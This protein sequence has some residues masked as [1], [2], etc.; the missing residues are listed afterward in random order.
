MKNENPG[1]QAGRTERRHGTSFT[2]AMF[3]MHSIARSHDIFQLTKEIPLIDIARQYGLELRKSGNRWVTRCP[4]HPDHNPSFYVFPDNRWCCFGCGVRGDAVDLVSRLMKLKPIEAAQLIARD[5]N[6]P[7][8]RPATPEARRRVEE[9]ARERELERAFAARVD[10]TYRRLALL[11]RCIFR[12]LRTFED[13]RQLSGLVHIQPVL[14][15]VLD[16]LVS[17]DLA[18]RVEALRFARNWGWGA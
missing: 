13:Y 3:F 9:A 8:N 11:Y 16:E 14:E 1:G 18:R 7:V 10:E 5:F 17:R 12:S 15:H 2:E 4:F 6:L